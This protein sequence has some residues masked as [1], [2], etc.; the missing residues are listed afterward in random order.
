MAS[1]STGRPVTI[2]VGAL[3]RLQV[4][5]PRTRPPRLSV[6]VTVERA[7]LT[8]AR[9][10]FG[11]VYFKDCPQQPNIPNY[12]LGLALITL[13]M[14]PYVTLPCG[15]FGAHPRELPKGFKACLLCLLGLFLY[16]WILAGDVWVFSIYQPNYDPAAADGLY[17]NK[18]LY[19]FA[20]WNAV[21][22]TF[23]ILFLLGGLCK[24]LMCC[25][26]MSPAPTNRDFDGNV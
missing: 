22:E 14:I 15:S 11:V 4:K 6:A 18:T 7:L 1:P 9:I 12:L 19:T 21:W 26:V 23:V 3:L 25:V 20:F 16:S 2:T 10:T 17:C 5:P 24:G 13:L 8:L